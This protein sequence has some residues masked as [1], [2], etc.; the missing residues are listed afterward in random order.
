M[1][2]RRSRPLRAR[3]LKLN[4]EDGIPQRFTSRPLR[5]RELKQR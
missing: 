5:A 3:E 4:L 1:E 2:I